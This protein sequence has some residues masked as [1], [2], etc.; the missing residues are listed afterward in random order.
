MESNGVEGGDGRDVLDVDGDVRLV[1][2]RHPQHLHVVVHAMSDAEG[3]CAQ[4]GGRAVRVEGPVACGDTSSAVVD[5]IVGA[6]RFGFRGIQATHDAHHRRCVVVDAHS[7]S[8]VHV[9]LQQVAERDGNEGRLAPVR[10]L[11][12]PATETDGRSRR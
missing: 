10:L 2:L 11:I 8:F 7:P 6:I 3:G 1:L 5:G 12:R 9:A 4:A